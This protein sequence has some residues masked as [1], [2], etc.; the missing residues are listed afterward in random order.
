MKAA[1]RASTAVSLSRGFILKSPRQQKMKIVVFRGNLAPQGCQATHS[2]HFLLT[3]RRTGPKKTPLAVE[4]DALRQDSF[5]SA[6]RH[7]W[8]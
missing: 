7:F 6:L 4:G 8:W 1:V 5:R 3:A 2:F